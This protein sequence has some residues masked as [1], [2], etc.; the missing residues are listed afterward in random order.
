MVVLLSFWLIGC[1]VYTQDADRLQVIIPGMEPCAG[2]RSARDI[3]L[4]LIFMFPHPV[5]S[6]LVVFL[7]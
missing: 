1:A 3:F 2:C 7:R 4:M 6:V 5:L